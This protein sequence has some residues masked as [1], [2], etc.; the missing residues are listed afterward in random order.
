VM[1]RFGHHQ[2]TKL[3]VFALENEALK[4]FSTG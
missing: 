1:E 2:L 3:F 4:Q